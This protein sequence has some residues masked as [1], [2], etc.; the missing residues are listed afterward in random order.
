MVWNPPIFSTPRNTSVAHIELASSETPGLRGLT[1][2]RKNPP[3][4]NMGNSRRESDDYHQHLQHYD[5]VL[6]FSWGK[7][8][9]KAMKCMMYSIQQTNLRCLGRTTRSFRRCQMTVALNFM[10]I[11]HINSLSQLSSFIIQHNRLSLIT[12]VRWHSGC[13]QYKSKVAFRSNKRLR[14]FRQKSL[15]MR[16][17]L[18]KFL[19]LLYPMVTHPNLLTWVIAPFSPPIPWVPWRF[20]HH[21]QGEKI[22]KTTRWSK[23]SPQTTP[24]G[25]LPTRGLSAKEREGTKRH[26]KGVFG[27]LKK[28]RC[29]RPPPQTIQQFAP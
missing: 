12:K 11:D 23:R 7:F 6:L 16:A 20:S 19:D 14:H 29:I 24:K 21:G 4:L 22:W 3:S 13:L 17:H 25:V 1:G 26:G 2:G 27:K 9:N 5:C 8:W 10:N 18:H 28:I 15:R